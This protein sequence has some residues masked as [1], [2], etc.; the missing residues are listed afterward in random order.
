MRDPETYRSERRN[1]W[2]DEYQVANR[3]WREFSA[4]YYSRSGFSI[5]ERLYPIAVHTRYGRSKYMPHE[6]VKRGGAGPVFA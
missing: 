6:S 4:D 3:P 1:V 5:P 2:R